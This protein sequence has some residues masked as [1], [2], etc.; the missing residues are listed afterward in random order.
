M[1]DR[2]DSEARGRLMGRIKAEG[3]RP[4]MAVRKHLHRAGFRFRLHR[5]DLPGR[6]DL[7]LRRYSAVV[8]VHGC[9]WHRHAGCSYAYTPKSRVEF[10]REKFSA[11]VRRDAEVQSRLRSAGWRVAV[12]W[13]CALRDKAAV[14]HLE[15]LVAWLPS[16]KATMEL[17]G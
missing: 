7:T 4:E 1:T 3:S 8:F 10:W 15:R 17:T 2:L 13:E 12:V 6:P 14:D 16:G 11:N 9:F 5:K